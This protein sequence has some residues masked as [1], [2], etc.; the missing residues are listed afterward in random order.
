MRKNLS[1]LFVLLCVAGCGGVVSPITT[2]PA[3]MLGAYDAANKREQWEEYASKGDVYAQFELAESYCCSHTEGTRDYKKSFHWFCEAG[4]NGNAKAQVK[5]GKLYQGVETL[6][7]LSVPKDDAR[8]YMW[9]SLAAR[10]VNPEAMKLKREL[11]KTISKNHLGDANYLLLNLKE[12]PCDTKPL[13]W[14]EEPKS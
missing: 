11:K 13:K 12:V 4:K 8:A 7:E 6:G 3:V 2:V 9:Y 1:L 10:R 5:L 14:S